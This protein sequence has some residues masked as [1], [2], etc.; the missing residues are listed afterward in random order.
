MKGLLLDWGGVLTTN[1][2]DSFRDFC[3]AEGL[4]PDAVKRLPGRAAGA[5]AG[6]PA[7]DRALSEDEFGNASARCSSSTTA[8]A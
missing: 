7:R 6:A 5:R 3:V 1:V 2:F 4:A 8:P